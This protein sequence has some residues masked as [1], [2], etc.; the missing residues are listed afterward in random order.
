MRFTP[1]RKL[2]LQE[3][4]DRHDHFTVEELHLALGE[5]GSRISRAS[6]Y[7]TMPVLIAAGLVAEVFREGGQA[8]YEHTYGHEHHCHLR[9]VSC[10]RVV[11][12]SDPSLPS[13]ADKVSRGH[14]YRLLGHCLELTGLCPKCDKERP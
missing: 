14:G 6:I 1:E 9:C 12:F 11:E 7:R 3:V 10:G 2:I 4:F 8:C 13:L 5:K